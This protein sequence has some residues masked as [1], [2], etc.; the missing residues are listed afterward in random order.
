MSEESRVYNFGNYATSSE[1]IA[2]TTEPVTEEIKTDNAK[3]EENV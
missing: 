2:E 3:K 1:E